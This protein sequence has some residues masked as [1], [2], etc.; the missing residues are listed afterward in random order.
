MAPQSHRIGAVDDEA[1][2]A[3]D[4]IGAQRGVGAGGQRGV[5]LE[6]LLHPVD[7]ADQ[8]LAGGGQVVEGDAQVRLVVV[9]ERADGGGEV[10]GLGELV[11]DVAVPP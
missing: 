1:E 9:D 7:A 2:Q 3:I 10:A 6:E 8:Q 11:A 4:A 5:E